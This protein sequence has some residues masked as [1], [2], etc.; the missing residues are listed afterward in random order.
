MMSMHRKAHVISVSFHEFIWFLFD[1]AT[2][3][4][5]YIASHYIVAILRKIDTCLQDGEW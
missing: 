1:F 2:F 3:A 5:H 4:L